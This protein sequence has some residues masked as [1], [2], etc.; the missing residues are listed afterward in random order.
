MSKYTSELRFICE[1]LAGLEESVGAS[2]VDTVIENARTKIFDF[3]YPIF[4]NLYKPTLEK[5]I[6]LHFYTREI[7][8]ETYGVWKIHLMAKMREM[9]PYYN[10]LY[11]SELLE[12]DPFKDVDKTIDHKG[13][14]SSVG[15]GTSGTSNTEHRGGTVVRDDAINRWD[16]YSDTPQGGISGIE[17][18]Y[19]GVDDNAYLTNARNIKDN[20]SKV[21]S[22]NNLTNTNNGQTVYNDNKGGTNNF[23][24]TVKGKQGTESY[25][26]L[27]EKYRRTLLNIDMQIIDELNELFFMLW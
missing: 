25:S 12:F 19:D 4:N 18:A 13:T 11:E 7:A 3:D 20:G 26:E 8:Y 9:M 14:T 6:L 21:T 22:T 5:K 1:S 23:V 24:E 17:A 15:T 10:K 27:L 16:L 2:N